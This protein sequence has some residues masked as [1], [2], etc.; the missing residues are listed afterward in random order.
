M[1]KIL[2]LIVVL[3]VL[4]S[5]MN[6][7]AAP[8][9]AGN[10]VIVRYGDGT[11]PVTN[12]GQT[13]FLDEYTTNSIWAVAGGFTAPIP[14]Q[15]I[16]MP[17]NWFGANAPVIADGTGAA[18]GQLSRSAD[19]R[20]LVM[21]GYG[22]TLSSGAS[23]TY[24]VTNGALSSSTVTGL[25][26]QVS[27]VVALV[28]GF[29]HVYTTTTQTNGNEEGDDPRCATT[30]EGTNIWMGGS[31]K[32]TKYLTRGSGVSTQVCEI[33]SIN[34]AMNI[35]SNVLYIDDSS[36]FLS[37]TN[38]TALVNPFGGSLP[39][40]SLPTNFVAV[41][42][43]YNTSGGSAFGFAMFNVRGG[44]GIDT[45]YV[46]DSATNCP[47]EPFRAGG[48]VLKFNITSSNTWN[49]S[50]RVCAAGA[51]WVAG[52][53]NGSNVALYITQ[54]GGTNAINVLYPYIDTGGFG[55]DPQ[56]NSD[57][58]DAN[59]YSE[60][61][62]P[63]S[64]PNANLIN[65]RGIAFAP[66]GGDTGTIT[67]PATLSIGP[68]Y[69][70]YFSGPAGGPF[71]PSSVTYSVAN[72]GTATTN[73]DVQVISISTPS[74]G[75]FVTVSPSTGS[76][77]PG[78]SMNVTVTPNGSAT[79]L[80]GGF[81]YQDR[82]LFHYGSSFGGS[83]FASPIAS[84]VDFAFFITPSSNFIAVGE[85]GGPFVPSSYV[86]VVSNA[87][88]G[89]LSWSA[90]T[91]NNWSSV[92]PTG[93]VLAAQAAI[94]VTVS[95]NANANSLAIGS[96]D[97]VV[98]FSN[99]SANAQLTTRSITLQS[100]F[101]IFDDFSTYADGPVV[102]QNNWL[103]SAAD[104]D[105]PVQIINGQFVVPGGCPGTTAQQPYK[106]VAA[107]QVTNPASYAIYGMSITFTNGSPNPNYTFVIDTTFLGTANS[108]IKD[109]GG[110]QYVWTTELNSYNTTPTV[111]TIPYDYYTNYLVFIVADGGNSNAWVFVNPGTADFNVLTNETP[112]VTSSGGNC[113]Y[114]PGESPGFNS[115]VTGQYSDC[116]GST[117]QGYMISKLAASTNYADVY[118]FL[119]GNTNVVS[120][121]AFTLWQ[122]QYFTVAELGTPSFSGPGAD[123]FGK[124]MS[125]TNQFLAGFN[126]TN[127][128][129]YVHI[130]AISKV[131]AGT[132]IQVNYL[133]ASGDSSR[134]PSLLS[135]TNVLEFTAGTGAGSY[136][137]NNFASTG[138]TNILSGGVGLGTLTNMVDPGGATNKPA[139]YYRV[140]VLVP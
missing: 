112:A 56:N 14:V 71:A 21:T 30:L 125:N 32:G 77:A 95:I 86:Y 48:G 8:F 4:A 37:P 49:Y 18:D 131:N 128:S 46:C 23:Q 75:S 91:S 123:P 115:V 140:R 50:G 137:S 120:T 35:Y 7:V 87:T 6:A 22:A 10:I 57:G 60:N 68:P 70:P 116:P 28:D 72:T 108:G 107:Q 66:Q 124:G 27:R 3:T 110:G 36:Q 11:Q 31:S 130:T 132:D 117:Q 105:S 42:G 109:I 55:A 81:T 127:A 102:G 84:L 1:K 63:A 85:P 5:G 9:G 54:G 25:F 106:Y 16:Q 98:T 13:I 133:G 29:G 129:A 97:D 79:G 111:G 59:Q 12:S 2:G 26:G 19:G 58:G 67:G 138:Q 39:T 103:A 34:R 80:N 15:S 61:L 90:G 122:N 121:D 139:R 45:I 82:L 113:S 52:T 64:A 20:Y 62:A 24:Q 51:T 96:Y 17:T 38:T 78:A 94:N 126:P 135:R 100:G 47:G 43:V 69:G 33:L 76:L 101:G 114:C 83:T 136:N 53:Q 40:S 99:I 118:N 89:A 104:P 119:T 88:L 93:G 92:S 41:P 74:G 65:T 134:S 44:S 73:F